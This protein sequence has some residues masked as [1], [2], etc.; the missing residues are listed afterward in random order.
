[1]HEMAIAQSI[2]DIIR[3]ELERHGKTRLTGVTVRHGRLTNIVPEALAMSFTALSQGTA[4]EGA[5]FV[6][7]EIPVRVRCWQC[8]YEFSPEDQGSTLCL[9]CPECGEDFGHQVISG[10]EL[11][12]DSIQAE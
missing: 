7:E 4:F 5:E 10:K 11:L 12:V 3:Q 8:G 9:P 1:M 2:A 6:M